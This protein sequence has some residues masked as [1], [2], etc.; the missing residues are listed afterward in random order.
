MKLKIEDK[1]Y[2]IGAALARPT[3]FLVREMKIRTGFGM[4]SLMEAA[5]GFEGKT[6][7]EIMDDEQLLG[8]LIA[9]IWLARRSAGEQLTFEEAGSFDMNAL[10]YVEDPD[11]AE[12]PGALEGPKETAP[13]PVDSAAAAGRHAD[14]APVSIT[15]LT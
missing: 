13:Q 12:L 1:V 14:G 7:P 6:G 4:K 3:L 15:S 2:D 11:P 9:M 8:A 10:E 5:E